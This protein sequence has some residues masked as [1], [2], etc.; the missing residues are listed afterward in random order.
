MEADSLWEG[1]DR[2]RSEVQTNCALYILLSQPDE[3]WKKKKVQCFRGMSGSDISKITPIDSQM[4]GCT[5]LGVKSSNRRWKGQKGFLKERVPL[6]GCPSESV[7]VPRGTSSK[8][9]LP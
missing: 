8:G 7:V 5:H 4:D 9:D 6:I 1:C 2:E 3:E